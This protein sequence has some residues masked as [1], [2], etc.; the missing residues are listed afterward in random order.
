MIAI[1]TRMHAYYMH[2]HACCAVYMYICIHSYE[3]TNLHAYIIR[4]ESMYVIN[5]TDGVSAEGE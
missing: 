4:C 2:M 3:H 1:F 5:A